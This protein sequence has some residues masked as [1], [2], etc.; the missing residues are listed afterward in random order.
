[1]LQAYLITIGQCTKIYLL[2]GCWAPFSYMHKAVSIY[3]RS[4]CMSLLTTNVSVSNN[5]KNIEVRG[6]MH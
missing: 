5:K 6:N 4:D 1:M 3:C 2:Y